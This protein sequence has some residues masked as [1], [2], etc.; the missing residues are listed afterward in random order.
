MNG[1]SLAAV[2]SGP[3]FLERFEVLREVGRGA[4]GIV[5]QARDRLADEG[6]ALKVIR[7]CD[8]D[9]A[10]RE[11]FTAEGELLRGLSHPSI[12]RV[13][14]FGSLGEEPIELA[15]H[16]FD[17][18]TPFV[19][20]EWLEGSDLA[21]VVAAARLDLRTSLECAR[22]VAGALR[23]AHAS[24]IAHRDVKPSNIFVLGRRE[25]GVFPHVKLVDFGVASAD[26]STGGSVTGTP[27]Y[28]APEQARGEPTLDVRCDVY[29]LGATLF[30]LCAGRPP[31]AGASS[32]ATLARLVS[33]PAPR[34]SELL[35]DVPE[36]LDD[37]VADMLSIEWRDRPESVEVELRLTELCAIPGLPAFTVALDA[38]GDSPHSNSSRLV[39]TMVALEV[40]RGIERDERIARMRELGA[41][42]VRLGKDAIVAFF[43]ARRARGGEAAKAV[44]I[45]KQLAGI[46]ARVGVATGRAL[47]DRARPVGEVGCAQR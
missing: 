9:P 12:V 24:G 1:A 33:T 11:R 4:S 41:E 43:G 6:V 8:S 20:M 7:L 13:V 10:D 18:G 2:P 17:A 16:H 28:M 32:I 3:S 42:A 22:Q 37:L 46:G 31:H 15:G 44:E 5:F 36:A 19:A 29:S 39:T 35:A 23:V 26:S 25:D 38:E 34:L 21:R 40:G 45:G 14:D 30:E 47:V 27:A